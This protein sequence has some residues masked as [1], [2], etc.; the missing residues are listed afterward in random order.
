MR[1]IGTALFVLAL[2][3]AVASAEPTVWDHAKRVR[4]GR[5]E[6]FLRTFGK[7]LDAV[8]QAEGD[9]EVMQDFRLAA[10]ATAELA[11]AHASEDP[12]VLL[13]LGHALLDA[14]IG[15]EE[16]ARGLAAR[17]LAKVGTQDA[18]LEEEARV[19]DALAA[20]GAPELAI[21]KVTVALPLIWSPARRSAL[22][23]ERAEAKLALGDLR[24]SVRDQRAALAAAERPVEK[25][26]ARFGLGLALERMGDLPSALVELRV[27]HAVAPRSGRT[28][29]SVLDEPGVFLF[30]DF[31]V[32]YVSALTSIALA[33]AAPNVEVARTEYE[34]A[35]TDWRRYR[36]A[37][38][39]DDPWLKNA[40]L[41][42]QACDRALA[43]LTPKR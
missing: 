7:W 2:W 40:D 25:A 29:L 9:P 8:P 32:H 24:G 11:G 34:R 5:S 37:A 6:A 39:S 31:D 35:Q 20:R 12:R 42:L 14:D 13:V 10:I 23:R 1:R 27:A 22:L 30:R 43:E 21:R 4:A 28:D 19:L 33:V 16:E 18:W 38:P 26:L 41:H 15:R 3:P 17:V 36:T